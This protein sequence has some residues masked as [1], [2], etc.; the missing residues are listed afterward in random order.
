MKPT[1]IKKKLLSAINSVSDNPRQYCH[2]PAVDFTRNRKI[3]VK[4][5][6]SGLI[7]MEAKTLANE[8]VD[9]F[10]GEINFPTPSAFI[11]Q[12]NK[13]KPEAFAEVFNTFNS[14]VQNYSDNELVTLAVDGSEIRIP[15]NPND[16]LT[17]LP[18]ASNAGPYNSL[19]LNALY[20]LN[21]HIYIAADIQNGAHKNE[22]ASLQQMV[23]KSPIPKALVIADRGYESYNNMA[24]IQEKGWF[25][26]IRIKDGKKNGIKMGFDLPTEREYDIP[27]NLKLV[28]KQTKEIKE[29]CKDRNCYRFIPH[30]SPFDYLPL[31]SRKHDPEVFYELTFRIVRF[32]LSEDSY[33]TILTNLDAT[34]YPPELLKKLYASRW[35]IET[36]FRNLKYTLGLLKFHS[37][38]AVCIRQEIY[39]KLI[40]YNFVEMITS[41]VAITKKQRKYTYKVNFSTAAHICRLFY[42]GKTSPP[43]LESVI[44]SSLIPI[45]P[46]R[47]SNRFAQLASQYTF[48]YRVA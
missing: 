43:Y 35:G 44:A 18:G 29:L 45:R 12:R 27:I 26:L 10:N 32:E 19:H 42:L 11:Q 7:G 36:S 28:R 24:H 16:S 5:L 37:K 14:N 46:D 1:S 39:A 17:R 9:L 30:T 34:E 3:S 21:K 4:S 15:D 2:N 6:I 41:H 38:K 48:F 23:D 20:D 22:H 33:E 31:K 40:M 25:F 13:L 47:H 8:L